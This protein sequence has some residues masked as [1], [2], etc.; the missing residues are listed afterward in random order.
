MEGNRPAN[1]VLAGIGPWAFSPRTG[2]VGIHAFERL[3][4][5]R[6]CG[7]KSA[8]DDLGL[9]PENPQRAIRARKIFWD[10]PARRERGAEL[11]RRGRGLA[12]TLSAPKA[13]R[14]AIWWPVAKGG[15]RGARPGMESSETERATIART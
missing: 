12:Q 4:Q 3:R 15:G 10:S 8:Q 5:R 11:A 9:V 1:F 7:I 6:G 13:Q 2:S 14:R